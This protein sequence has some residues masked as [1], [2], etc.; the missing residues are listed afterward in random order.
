M[1][2]EGSPGLT[3]TVRGF[4]FV[5]KS[6]VYFNGRSVPYKAA[7]GTEL[8]VTLDADLL[9]TPGRF[10]L[11]V[12]NPE[13]IGTDSLWGNGTSNKAHLVVNYRQ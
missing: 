3:V 13:P 6:A 5:R 7:T 1:V 12:K 2:T 4:N 8:Q 9:R 11:F 10:E